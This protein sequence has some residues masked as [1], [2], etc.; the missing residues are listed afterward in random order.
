MHVLDTVHVARVH[1]HLQANGCSRFLENKLQYAIPWHLND[2]WVIIICQLLTVKQDFLL[3][4]SKWADKKPGHSFV[5]SHFN[6]GSRHQLLFVLWYLHSVHK[7]EKFPYSFLQLSL[8][9]G[10]VTR[11]CDILNAWDRKHHTATKHLEYL[12]ICIDFTIYSYWAK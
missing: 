11:S 1:R 2:D 9:W 12:K 8:S 10:T 4:A 3:C 7:N 6:R 5:F